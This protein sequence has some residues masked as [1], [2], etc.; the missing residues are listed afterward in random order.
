MILASKGVTFGTAFLGKAK[1]RAK[2][3]ARWILHPDNQPNKCRP[4][5]S[6]YKKAGS[7]LF[8]VIE[9]MLTLD[10]QYI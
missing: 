9:N 1:T 2:N 3:R 6:S 4:P 10:L 5:N 8:V 7:L